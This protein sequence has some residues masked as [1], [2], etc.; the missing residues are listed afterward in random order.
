MKDQS[1]TVKQDAPANHEQ[2]DTRAVVPPSR[3]GD[4]CR[5][6]APAVHAEHWYETTRAWC[7][8]HTPWSGHF[9][10][11]GDKLVAGDDPCK[12]LLARLREP[13]ELEAA[14]WWAE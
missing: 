4:I 12:R 14:T 1:H 6:G 3:R 5:C 8:E 2:P 9:E 10:W 11:C 13:H 7:E